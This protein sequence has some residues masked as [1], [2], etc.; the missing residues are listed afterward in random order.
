MAGKTTD[1]TS[2]GAKSKGPKAGVQYVSITKRRGSCS[3]LP[4]VG[5]SPYKDSMGWGR[6][7]WS[8]VP[9]PRNGS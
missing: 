4:P 2:F 7:H 9:W 6:E 8:A 5:I 3:F 1:S